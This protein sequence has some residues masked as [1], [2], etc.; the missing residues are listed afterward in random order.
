MAAVVGLLERPPVGHSDVRPAEC[1]AG[2]SNRA[3]VVPVHPAIIMRAR[4]VAIEMIVDCG[5]SSGAIACEG[6]DAKIAA[7]AIRRVIAVDGVSIRI[8]LI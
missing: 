6:I 7:I 8:R 3:K 5:N 1:G 4:L 2:P